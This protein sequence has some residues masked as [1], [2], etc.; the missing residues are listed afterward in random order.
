MTIGKDFP[1]WKY[2]AYFTSTWSAWY[3]FYSQYYLLLTLLFSSC[4]AWFSSYSLLPHFSKISHELSAP[5][6]H[7]VFLDHSWC[8]PYIYYIYK[9]KKWHRL[10]LWKSVFF[11]NNLIFSTLFDFLVNLLYYILTE[12]QV[13]YKLSK[14]AAILAMPLFLLWQIKIHIYL[15]VHFILL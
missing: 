15:N 8:P 9:Y 13:L 6:Q 11:K 1:D 12:L 14:E 3:E 10:K 7:R 2:S 5:L 4:T